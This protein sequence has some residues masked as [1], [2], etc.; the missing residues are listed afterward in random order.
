MSSSFFSISAR[1]GP[2]PFRYSM[3]VDNMLEVLD[4]SNQLKLKLCKFNHFTTKRDP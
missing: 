4:I 3:G 2:T 1:T